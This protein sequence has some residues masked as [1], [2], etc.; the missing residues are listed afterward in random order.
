MSARSKA[1]ADLFGGRRRKRPGLVVAVGVGREGPPPPPAE[2][3]VGTE[4]MRPGGLGDRMRG[5]M[6][7]GPGETPQGDASDMVRHGLE[8]LAASGKAW[9]KD[10]L[11][12]FERRMGLPQEPQPERA[13][14]AEAE[15]PEEARDLLA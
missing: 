4:P 14:R 3:E 13:G 12:E 6:E 10:M 11:E 15:E 7:R 5:G 1:M 2:G 8:E 9:A